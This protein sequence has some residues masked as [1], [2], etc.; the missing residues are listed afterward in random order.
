MFLR[1]LDVVGLFEAW[2][3]S[4]FDVDFYLSGM[5]ENISGQRNHHD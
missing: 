1:L 2:R 5:K 3:G 4:G